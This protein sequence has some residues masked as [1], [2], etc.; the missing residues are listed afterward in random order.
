MSPTG[1]NYAPHRVIVQFKATGP[2]AVTDDVGDLV[3]TGKSFQARIASGSSKLDGIFKSLKIKSARN[4]FFDRKGKT[5]AQTK[6]AFRKHLKK[7]LEHKRPNRSKLADTI[8]LDLL[9]TYI[10]D[11]DP[12]VN[13]ENVVQ[14][15]RNDDSVELAELDF[16]AKLKYT[17]NDPYLNSS[18]NLTNSNLED[19]WGIKQIGADLAWTVTQGEGVVVAV[20]DSGVDI[21][22]PDIYENVWRN[23]GELPYP[24]GIDDDNNGFVDDYFGVDVT[25]CWVVSFDLRSECTQ[26][27]PTYLAGGVQGPNPDMFYPTDRIGHGTHVAGTIAAAGN[28]GIGVIGVAPKAKIMPIKAFEKIEQGGFWSYDNVGYTTDLVTAIR[29]AILNGADVIN[30]SWST[31]KPS[32]ALNLFVRF[33]HY[34]EI[35]VVF[36][37]EYD[38]VPEVG[39]E[40]I[41]RP[42][43]I[44]VA[45]VDYSH[46]TN[47]DYLRAVEIDVAAPG[48][49]I[50]SLN[51]HY[52]ENELAKY[53]RTIG[54]GY[55]EGRY[56]ELSG[57]SGAVPHVSGVI[58]LLKSQN[59][60]LKVEEI[61]QILRKTARDD[62]RIPGF[63]TYT[64]PGILDAAE[65]VIYGSDVIST[66]ITNPFRYGF[67]NRRK[68]SRL[69]VYGYA[70]GS[71]P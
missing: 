33:A 15:L 14:A 18:G 2:H 58:A 65:A 39:G 64:G 59:P 26:Y 8:P 16:S 29:Y 13:V 51:A 40:F 12:S 3:K 27:N 4:L 69:G 35:P 36:P 46:K 48:S 67:I 25:K 32:A 10:L 42:Y 6:I 56:I 53:S 55:S 37:V 24:N 34:L 28:N 61:R 49:N 62:M 17:P 9:N 31:D 50:L 52:G 7:Q 47:I 63:D 1:I 41:A 23:E 38:T 54:D 45:S 71:S 22:H 68:L 19:L 44:L 5:L 20:I 57:P 70:F 21:S 43:S 66:L 60:S 11:I 30:A